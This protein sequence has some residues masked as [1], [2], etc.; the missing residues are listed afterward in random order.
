[1]HSLLIASLRLWF[2]NN[3]VAIMLSCKSY[4]YIATFY[5]IIYFVQWLTDELLPYFEQWLKS[6][7]EQEG[8]SVQRNGM[9]M[10]SQ[11]H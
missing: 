6:V 4:Y 5:V 7:N 9:M 1:M 10:I 3:T 8:F 11:N 2:L